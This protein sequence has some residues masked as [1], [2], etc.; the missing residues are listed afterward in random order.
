[1]ENEETIVFLDETND[2]NND[3]STK[4]LNRT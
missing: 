1:L 2:N 3:S 4:H